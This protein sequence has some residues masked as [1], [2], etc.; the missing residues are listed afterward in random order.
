MPAAVE[1]FA[2]TGQEP[3]H[4]LGTKVDGNLSAAEMLSAAQLDWEVGKFDTSFRVGK[5]G[6]KGNTTIKTGQQALVRLTDNK[7][8]S[9]SVGPNWEPIQ[10]A[11]AFEFFHEFVESGKMTMETAGSLRDGRIVFG[12]AKVGEDFELFGGDRVESYLLFSNSHQYGDTAKV[13]FTPIRVVCNNTLV[14]A[15]S[16]KSSRAVTIDHRTA[17][18]PARV[19]E[20]M[21]IAHFKLDAYKQAAQHLGSKK[22]SKDDV[23]EYFKTVFPLA[24]KDPAEAK[25][26]MSNNA[27]RAIE[28]LDA[29]P[30]AEFAEGTWWQAFNATTYMADHMLSKD[31]DT[32]LFNSWLG[33]VRDLKMKAMDLALQRAS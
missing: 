16:K 24:I 25:K 2:Y 21:G 18:D 1:T 19:K 23:I 20:L 6:E 17:F 14:M 9:P 33:G 30:G 26:E 11:Q 13:D 29:Q 12:L 32:R 15:L 7:V 10:N 4:G 31:A 27:K 5:P 22:A 3:W 8:L 28:V